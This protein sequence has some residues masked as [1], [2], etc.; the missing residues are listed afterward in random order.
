M[1]WQS[2]FDRLLKAMS[3]GEPH[4]AKPRWPQ[5]ATDLLGPSAQTSAG[6]DQASVPEP[7]ACSSDTQTPQDTSGDASR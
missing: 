1:G 6:A 2:R 5:S 7:D 3:H 4:K